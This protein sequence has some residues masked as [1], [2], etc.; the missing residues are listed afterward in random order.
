MRRAMLV[1]WRVQT[2]LETAITV[3]I[4]TAAL[5]LLVYWGYWSLRLIFKKEDK[6]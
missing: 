5:P 4:S 6:L 3:V 2:F 1:C